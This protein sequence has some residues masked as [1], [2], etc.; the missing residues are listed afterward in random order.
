MTEPLTKIDSAV[1]GLDS[2]V[3]KKEAAKRRQ[4]SA[5]APGVSKI[6]ELGA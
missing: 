5:A 4:S 3:D 1:Q 6:Q 2:P